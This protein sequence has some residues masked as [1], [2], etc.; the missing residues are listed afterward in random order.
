MGTTVKLTTLQVKVLTNL[1]SSEATR[2]K[3]HENHVALADKLVIGKSTVRFNSLAEVQA[4]EAFL[5]VWY[6]EGTLVIPAKTVDAISQKAIDAFNILKQQEK[7]QPVVVEEPAVVEEESEA[8]ATLPVEEPAADEGPVVELPSDEEVGAIVKLMDSG[9]E[10]GEESGV[11]EESYLARE[12]YRKAAP[13]PRNGGFT[14]H[15]S[16]V[17]VVDLDG[18]TEITLPAGYHWAIAGKYQHEANKQKRVKVSRAKRATPAN[19]FDADGWMTKGMGEW[20]YEN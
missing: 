3:V 19:L 18:K 20:V 11:D 10:A 8:L 7:E 17:G 16:C 4:V 14:L 2:E 9:E 13:W 6:D 5:I 1:I 12:E 15:K